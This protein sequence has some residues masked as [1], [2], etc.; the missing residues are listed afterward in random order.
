MTEVNSISALRALAGMAPGDLAFIKGHTFLGDGGEGFFMWKTGAWF[1]QDTYTTPNGTFASNPYYFDNDGTIIW[2]G[3]A[4][5]HDDSGRWVRVNYELLDVRYFGALGGALDYTSQIQRALN[6]GGDNISIVNAPMRG[7]TVFI[8]NGAYVINS[9]EVPNGVSLLGDSM[10][11]SIL[12]GIPNSLS[13]TPLLTIREGVVEINIS[14][15]TFAGNNTQQGCMR[16]KGSLPSTPS[17][18]LGGLQLSTFKNIK[19]FG[20]NGDGISLLGGDDARD[21]LPNQFL[22]FEN[23]RVTRQANLDFPEAP[24]A[25]CLY[26]KGQNAQMS[27]IN[28]TFDGWESRDV[29]DKALF[30]LREN[31]R[32]ENTGETTSGVISFINCTIQM[33][34]Y[35][36]RMFYAENITFDNCWFENLG[37]TFQIESRL[38][39]DTPKSINVL[40]SRFVNAAGFG[41][42]DVSD[43]NIRFGHCF[44]ITRGQVNIFNNYTSALRE[45]EGA[46]ASAFL[47]AV[48]G[49]LGVN[50]IG[51]YYIGEYTDRTDGITQSIESLAETLDCIDN[52]M[53]F[54][55]SHDDLPITTIVSKINAGES[56]CIRATESITLFD[57]SVSMSPT[58]NIFLTNRQSLKL[59]KEEV[60]W[61]TKIEYTTTNALGNAIYHAYQLTSLVKTSSP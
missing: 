45:P 23:V 8:P 28:C 34:N 15:L 14:N 32:I 36:I 3:D 25:R 1:T 58:A 31:V 53:V 11:G 19:I 57:F 2:V 39:D 37:V 27:F 52:K 51:N 55:S 18:Q 54:V 17:P 30:P 48:Q 5:K 16:F 7:A 20:F 22:V 43:A 35:G 21:N 47:Y 61:F 12:Y 42:L 41:V 24:E 10:C 33:A 6:F 26:M 59:K 40:N 46:L 4:Q 56:I 44:N 50:T 9:I 13:P 29:N 38:V 49:N 60:A